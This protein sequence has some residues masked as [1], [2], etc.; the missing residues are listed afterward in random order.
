MKKLLIILI[1]VLTTPFLGCADDKEKEAI[2]ETISSSLNENYNVE[3]TF[4]HKMT[5]RQ[6]LIAAALKLYSDRDEE[7][8]ELK[9]LVEKIELKKQIGIESL[10]K[11][12]L[13]KAQ[14]T[15]SR[16]EDVDKTLYLI[17]KKIDQSP[18]SLTLKYYFVISNIQNKKGEIVETPYIMT[19]DYEIVDLY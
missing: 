17:N 10:Y 19:L 9:Y 5:E 4:Y 16:L 18:D 6:K 7:L 12:D 3:I 11:D 1:V 13:K 2:I 14:E 15:K 8:S